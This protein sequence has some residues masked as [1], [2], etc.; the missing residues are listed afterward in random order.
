MIWNCG[1]P[2]EKASEFLDF[3]LKPIM[4]SGKS[5]MKD[6]GDLIKK[7][8]NLQNI[9]EAAI[10]VTADVVSLYTSNPHEAGF[11]VF[12]KVLDNTGNIDFV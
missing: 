2:T 8:K 3:R 11:N 4:Q 12:R 10:L 6:S 5:S 9:P 1:T 7:I